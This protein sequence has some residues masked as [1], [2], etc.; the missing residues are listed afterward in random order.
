MN[1]WYAKFFMY[2]DRYHVMY[3]QVPTLS[4]A[5]LTKFKTIIFDDV[6]QD[7]TTAV[8]NLVNS[9]RDGL[10]IDRDLLRDCV[11]QY[12]K[13]GMGSLT[14]YEQD[15]ESVFL[16]LSRFVD[17]RCSHLCFVD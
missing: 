17:F 15:F 5:G 9:E 12:L 14:V 13:L 1:K 3:T 8:L 16:N 4:E 2:L 10:V 7:V 6:K 11:S